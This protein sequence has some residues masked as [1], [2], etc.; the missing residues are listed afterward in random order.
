M[1]A[2]APWLGSGSSE[3]SCLM[4][5]NTN[6]SV[7]VREAAAGEN[8]TRQQVNIHIPN[9]TRVNNYTVNVFVCACHWK[10]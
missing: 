9:T 3:V 1:V 5:V 7:G 4:V 8:N 2:P 10:H 6:C